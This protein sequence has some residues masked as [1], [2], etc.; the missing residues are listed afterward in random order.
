MHRCAS[1][2]RRGGCNAC[3]GPWVARR[4]WMASRAAS[5]VCTWWGYTTTSVGGVWNVCVCVCV[6]AWFVWPS[7]TPL[8]PA[9]HPNHTHTKPLRSPPSTRACSRSPYRMGV[10]NSR[11]AADSALPPV[12]LQRVDDALKLKRMP[13]CMGLGRMHEAIAFG[14]DGHAAI[15]G[16]LLDLLLGNIVRGWWAESFFSIWPRR[17]SWALC[18]DS[19]S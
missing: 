16:P 15:A 1:V 5:H 9:T 14:S 18:T 7:P 4:L 19:W 8:H 2:G 17:Q 12:W 13:P 3:G 11:M 10:H 6:C